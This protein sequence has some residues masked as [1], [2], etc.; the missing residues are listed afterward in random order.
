MA[1]Y[2][3]SQKAAIIAESRRL[4]SHDT[5]AARPSS[6]PSPPRPL[7][8]HIEFKDPVQEWREWHDARAQEREEAK[9]ELQRTARESR[10]AAIVSRQEVTSLGDRVTELEQ[11]MVAVEHVLAVLGEGMNGAAAFT[12]NAVARFEDTETAFKSLAAAIDT[13]R[14]NTKSELAAL[15]DRVGNKETTDTRKDIADLHAGVQ[16]V[17]RLIMKNSH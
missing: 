7:P 8:T 6:S 11:H 17:T 10:R 9:A 3:P 4:L 5:S 12:A 13:V 2:T 1:T 14:E 15:R 16:N